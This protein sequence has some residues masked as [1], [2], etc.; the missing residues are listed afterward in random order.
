MLQTAF[1]VGNE[2][3][4]AVRGPMGVV[5]VVANV[6][7]HTGVKRVFS[8]LFFTLVPLFCFDLT[9]LGVHGGGALI[10]VQS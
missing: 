3:L 1:S 4:W 10:P 6:R 9:G 7:A 5:V 2:P 8:A